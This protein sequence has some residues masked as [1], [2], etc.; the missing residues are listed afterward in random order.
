MN[1]NDSVSNNKHKYRTNNEIKLISTEDTASFT[2]DDNSS[3]LQNIMKSYTPYQDGNKTSTQQISNTR[4]DIFESDDEEDKETYTSYPEL[5]E[6][7][8]AFQSEFYKEYNQDQIQENN[9]LEN[10][11]TSDEIPQA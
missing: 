2:S 9:E 11:T 5:Q 8:R 1:D 4:I 6:E 7:L 3:E 10:E